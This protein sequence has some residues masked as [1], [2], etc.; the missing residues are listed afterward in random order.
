MLDSIT[1]PPFFDVR[2]FSVLVFQGPFWRHYD[3][4]ASLIQGLKYIRDQV[5]PAA[6]KYDMDSLEFTGRPGEGMDPDW[7]ISY[8]DFPKININYDDP[9]R[10]WRR[11]FFTRVFNLVKSSGL[12][13]FV[14][15]HEPVIPSGFFDQFPKLQG[16]GTP[17]CFSKDVLYQFLKSKYTE[18]LTD[19]PQIDGLVISFHETMGIDLLTDKLCQCPDCKKRE[20]YRNIKEYSDAIFEVCRK[21]DKKLVVR[22][23]SNA[24]YREIG[25]HTEGEVMREVFKVLDP[26]IYLMSKY[27]PADFYG[28]EFPSDPIIGSIP[29]RKFI[30]EFSLLREWSGRGFLPHLTPHDF[31]RRIQ[32]MA[33][34]KC[35]GAVGRLDWP[36]INIDQ[37]EPTLEG[38]AE[39][40]IFTFAHLMHDHDVDIEKLWARW[41]SQYVGEDAQ[42]TFIKALKRSED[43]NQKI[44]FN[45][46]FVG[47]SYHN[48]IPDPDRAEANLWVK[49]LAKWDLK[50]EQLFHRIYNPDLDM[51]AELL[52]EKDDAI[53]QAQ[54]SLAE[55]KTLENK[56]DDVLY[57][58]LVYLF[59]KAEECGQVWKLLTEVFYLYVMS[60]R[61]GNVFDSIKQRLYEAS[62]SLL[63][64]GDAIVKM[65]GEKS[66]PV[67][68]V[69]RG[70][71]Y[72]EFVARIWRKIFYK[73][74]NQAPPAK[75]TYQAADYVETVPEFHPGTVEHLWRMLLGIRNS[76]GIMPVTISVPA[77]MSEIHIDEREFTVINSRS[78]SLTLPIFR[79]N[80]AVDIETPGEY[81]ASVTGNTLYGFDCRIQ[82]PA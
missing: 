59:M 73:H 43:I 58:R 18:F 66:W 42:N 44:F 77:S 1:L 24:H 30:V 69:Y 10:S 50:Y 8:R 75:I 49:N 2:R 55:V 80:S 17:L 64:V 16:E 45:K 7:L 25:K 82:H 71:N 51:I 36:N 81:I 38:L 60:L 15:A 40:N 70:I 31:K 57:E 34:K 32:S 33:E 76:D 72:N 79:V 22:N 63:D 20:R 46:G 41:A 23:F 47:P 78:E 52:T 39:F 48:T 14:W 3:Q 56:I 29:N 21:S 54:L 37:Y 5:I 65:R 74:I 53:E 68:A 13:L 9:L 6:V 27:C 61:N 35:A 28:T 26:E 4:Q 19:F 62:I 12:E 67:I 11:D